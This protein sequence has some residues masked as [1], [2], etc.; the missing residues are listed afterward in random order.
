[1]NLKEE[2]RWKDV[3]EQY[4]TEIGASMVKYTANIGAKS[5]LTGK[6]IK[7]INKNHFLLSERGLG[8]VEMSLNLFDKTDDELD[9]T[10]CSAIYKHKYK[11]LPTEESLLILKKILPTAGIPKC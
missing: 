6:D 1:M 8:L 11:K 4:K 10:A 5:N 3:I 9:I 7:M 2:R